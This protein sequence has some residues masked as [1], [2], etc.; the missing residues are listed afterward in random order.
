MK[1]LALLR[2]HLIFPRHDFRPPR[3]T[4]LLTPLLHL[5]FKTKRPTSLPAAFRQIN[6][7][8]VSPVLPEQFVER[9]L[10]GSH[11]AH[12]LF[13]AIG[14]F[15]LLGLTSSATFGQT[16]LDEIGIPTFTTALPVELGFVNLANGN[17]H[18]EIPIA[19][20]PQRGKPT[21]VGRLA[22]DSRVWIVNP[23]GLNGYQWQPTGGWHFM[24]GAEPG[25]VSYTYSQQL[26]NCRM[27]TTIYQ[28]TTYN[29]FS[30]QES[31]G[32]THNFMITLTQNYA[33]PQN[34]ISSFGSYA[35]DN[36]GFYMN[37]V[38]YGQTITVTA[39]DGT[40]VYPKVQDTNGNYISTDPNTGNYIDTLQRTPFTFSGST[41]N[42]TPSCQTTINFL[43]SQGTRSQ[44]TLNYQN[45]TYDSLS[46]L[47]ST[48]INSWNSTAPQ[49]QSM[50]LPNGTSYI[51]T[52]DIGCA[53]LTGITLPT[54]GQLGYGYSNFTDMFG[55][56]NRWITSRTVNGNTWSMIPSSPSCNSGQ[57]LCQQLVTVTTPSHDDR[58]FTFSDDRITYWLNQEQDFSGS[59]TSGGTLL[60]TRTSDINS[61]TNGCPYGTSSC[62]LKIRDTVIWPVS[63]GTL[64]KKTEYS[65]DGQY[66]ANVTAV[67]E[68]NYYSNGA[69]PTSPDRE[70]D[71]AYVTNTNYTN[72]HITNL[73]ST[74]QTKN[75]S[76]TVVAQ[77]SYSYD[78]TSPA[79]T[80]APQHASMTAYRGNPTTISRWL[81]TNSSWL[82]TTF[83]YDNTGNVLTSTDPRQMTTNYSYAD[84]WSGSGC[85][86][87]TTFAYLTKITD[88]LSHRTQNTYYP[89]TGLLQ[90]AQD[91]NDIQ[92]GRSGQTYSYDGSNR[93]IQTN[94]SDGGQTSLAF[95]D[96]SLP[97]TVTT[98]SKIT[99]TLNLIT[100][101]V[102]DGYGRV[103]QSQLASDPQGTVYVDTTYDA[104]GR[105]ATV[106][107]P[108]RTSND[109]GPTNG[110]TT[111][112]Y[113]ALNRK[114]KV[115]P[116]DGTSSSNNTATTYV[117]N[118]TTKT[119]QAGKMRESC[120]D[121]L[122]RLTQ[123]FEPNASNS[124]V[125][126]TDYQYDALNNLVCAVQRGTDTT[127]FTTCAAAS[128]TW[129]P[130]SFAYNSLSELLSATNPESGTASYTYDLNGNM[131]TKIAPL[132][133]Q[134]GTA[135][136][137][138]SFSYDALNRVT[139]K[140][141]SDGITPTVKYAYDGVA[142]TGC[143][144]PTL[145]IHNGVGRRTGMCDA[146][147]GEAWSYDITSGMGWKVTDAR[148]TNSITKTSVS[149]TNFDG[150][151]AT[152]TYPSG[153]IIT[154]TSNAAGRTISAVD[155][156]GPINYATNAI[157]SP[158][159]AL[160]S[161]Q[162]GGSLYSTFLF[163]KRLQPCWLY[164]TTTSAGAP[165]TCSQTGVANA[166]TLDYQYDLGLG[167]ADN[168][169]VNGITNRRDPTRSQAFTYDTV[170]RLATA[171]TQTVGVTIPNPNCWGL[172]FGYDVWGN[173]LTSST[174]GP[175][176]C[177]EPLP[178]N[179]SVTTA[180][181]PTGYCYDAAGNLL[182]QATCPPSNPVYAYTYD[183]ENHMTS[184][185]GVTYTY[186]GTGKRVQKS[187]G[188]LY[189]YGTESDPLDETDLAGNT[190]NS[191]FY[192][193]TF[194][195][196]KRIARRDSLNSVSYYFADHLGTARVV[197]NAGGTILDDS[198][199]YPFGGE[200]PV[201]GPN[202][203]N[204][205]K[206]SSKERDIESGL[207]NFD[208][209]Y[210]GSSLGRF[211]SP[212]P[213][214]GHVSNPQSLNRYTYVLN[215][216]LTFVDPFGLD[217]DGSFRA[218]TCIDWESLKGSDCLTPP[219]IGN[220]IP[221]GAPDVSVLGTSAG[222]P[223]PPLDNLQGAAG[224]TSG[225]PGA[226]SSSSNS[227]LDSTQL[228][229]GLLGA[230]PGPIGTGAN[231]VN[232]GISL[233]RGN[234]GQAALN[235]AFAIPLVGT[236][237]RFA[238]LGEGALEA[239]KGVEGI[240]EFVG[241]SGKIYVGQSGNIG[242]RLAQ[243]LESGALLEEGISSVRFTEVSGGRLAREI[244]EQ[245]RINELGGVRNLQNLRNAIGTAREYLMVPFKY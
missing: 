54:G 135:T 199:F 243:H 151:L 166:T 64:Q 18:L 219:D 17:M 91:E 156:T 216:P 167:V 204:A 187:N 66:T 168:G 171:Q 110:I 69:F 182:L 90:S 141:Y 144:V 105:I 87:A 202:S 30:W 61:I 185:A 33:C 120:V 223:P 150:S 131:L 101:S 12:R 44:V 72:L 11:R 228:G 205:Y 113:D 201:T 100:K 53:E 140:S 78:Q 9:T 197:V 96:P 3:L 31:N 99:S 207:D 220:D 52:Y 62:G 119:D 180:N 138:T 97:Q 57:T 173:L 174:T 24:P 161:V 222:P 42:C 239:A 50:V 154:Y 40:Q 77:T 115:I 25:Y 49:L 111:Y 73:P 95:N 19:S 145:T 148:T 36:S 241:R 232:A 152:L 188:K 191:S 2:L 211:T 137:T 190:N 139:Q 234:Y 225:N 83:G 85:V 37:V 102:S 126:E 98:T 109:P 32:T 122:G 58:V 47:P 149:Q 203:A 165:S 123:V 184:T 183:A 92:N 38:N 158:Q 175:S 4:L 7:S 212:D 20:Y 229:L 108:Y 195:N 68:W 8:D 233:Y 45:A 194:F 26:P 75:A 55:N 237:G 125:N 146:A 192:E 178:L 71:T 164:A 134:T 176:G 16:Y 236:F 147:G 88:T 86:A 217:A 186:D 227:G 238:Q 130:R 22:Y 80:T 6:V 200:R 1:L 117:A 170:N 136:I 193:Y 196:G 63:G 159:G 121:G 104:L 34:N 198:D 210:F 76:G 84:S 189:W 221:G 177:G 235:A 67:K 35:T 13:V 226:G 29:G 143:T 39:K 142:P 230:I 89:C 213:L 132:P 23:N 242:L 208:F 215:N 244:A 103:T 48:G 46:C 155:S 172:T 93:L 116:P 206:F 224:E 81:N 56:V 214:G 169:N 14:F 133:N 79:A 127:G 160:T 157:Y 153:R 209:R 51:F 82:S 74:I 94:S 59:S 231:L 5:L 163:N 162:N 21:L 114:I 240:Y 181:R 218:G 27:G 106:S 124:L 245:L 10:K 43:N 179:F 118:C 112:Q 15:I 60:L 129:R 41:G 107:N 70:T 28:T 65:Y 128:A